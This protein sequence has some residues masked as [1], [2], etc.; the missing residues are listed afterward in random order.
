MAVHFDGNWQP[1]GFTSRQASLTD[2]L[3]MLAVMQVLFTIAFFIVRARTPGAQWPTLLFAYVFLAFF[4]YANN[5][6]VER[7]LS[8]PPTHSQSKGPVAPLA[9]KGGVER[10]LTARL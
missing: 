6:I 8:H 2:A 10:S 1:N 9:G 4:W 5:S 7:N 3:G